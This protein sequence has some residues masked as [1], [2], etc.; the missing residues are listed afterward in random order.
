[1]TFAGWES[2]NTL[3]QQLSYPSGTNYRSVLLMVLG[4]SFTI[5]LMV[6]RMRFLWWPFHPAGYALS[7]NF[8]TD[9][10]WFCLVIGSLIKW[11]ILKHGGLKA[12]RKAVPF[13]HGLILGEF[14]VGSFGVRSASSS[15]GQPI[16]SF[17][18]DKT[19]SFSYNILHFM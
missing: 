13:F 15:K 5:M 8:G 11:V 14:V 2:F 10:I 19:N 16:L 4:F 12:H 1:M 9:Y 3:Q 7:I 17:F 6:M 18:L